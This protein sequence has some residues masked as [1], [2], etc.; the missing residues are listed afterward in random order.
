MLD[1]LHLI[2]ASVHAFKQGYFAFALRINV[3]LTFFPVPIQ[4]PNSAYVAWLSSL[5][6]RFLPVTIQKRPLLHT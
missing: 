1:S 6:Q 2:F 3:A 4:L 5:L